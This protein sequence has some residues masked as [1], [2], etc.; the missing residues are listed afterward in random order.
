MAIPRKKTARN[1]IVGTYGEDLA[2]AEARK[3]GYQIRGRNVRT[4]FGEIDLFLESD[5]A[6]VFAEVK[7]RRSFLYGFPEDAVTPEK[8]SRMR[9]CA[10]FVINRLPSPELKPFQ[11]DVITLERAEADSFVLNW[12]ENV[13]R[14]D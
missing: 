5:S 12:M 1:R 2:A 6:F 8:L 11:L 3:R 13:T 4:P 10:E 14:D 7:T 9:N